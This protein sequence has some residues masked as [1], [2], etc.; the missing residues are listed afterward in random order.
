M[1]SS[2]PRPIRPPSLAMAPNAA[3]RVAGLVAFGPVGDQEHAL[4]GQL[5]VHAR[6]PPGRSIA[7]HG[8]GGRG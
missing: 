3:L 7:Q 4:V 6:V 2:L 8:V 5:H 1:I